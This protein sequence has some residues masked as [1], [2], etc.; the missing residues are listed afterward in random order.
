MDSR[1]VPPGVD[2]T[3]PS[4]GRLYDF[5]LNGE[6]HLPVDEEAAREILNKVPETHYL[7]NANRFFLQ[8]AA[9]AIARAGVRQFIDIGAGIPTQFNTHEVVHIIEPDATVVYV[10]NDPMVLTHAKDIL[11][12]TREKNVTY[13]DGDI[14]DPASILE[15]PEVHARIDFNSPVGYLHVAI[16]HFVPDE[17]DPWRLVR[18]YMDAVPSGS[19]LALSHFTADGQ[20]PDKVQKFRDIYR[21]TTTPACHRTIKD[22]ARFFDGLDFLP[23]YDDAEPGLSFIDKWGSKNPDEVDPAHTWGPCGVARKP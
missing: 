20:R 23:P 21:N 8:R 22:I 9:A 2:P 12:R 6:H 3:R 19:Y 18:Q 15:N 14:R 16:W 17:L 4:A 13:V 7:A 10:D 5:F 11:R 1:T